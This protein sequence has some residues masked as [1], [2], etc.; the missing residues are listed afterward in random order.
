MEVNQQ[1]VQCPLLPGRTITPGACQQFRS[2]SEPANA[3]SLNFL[4]FFVQKV[5]FFGQVGTGDC[6]IAWSLAAPLLCYWQL[7]NRALMHHKSTKNR[8]IEVSSVLF[9]LYFTPCGYLQF[10]SQRWNMFSFNVVPGNTYF[11][12]IFWE[13]VW[14]FRAAVYL[15]F[16]RQVNQNCR[17]IKSPAVAR[18]TS[19]PDPS[20]QCVKNPICRSGF[21]TLDF[22]TLDFWGN[23]IRISDLSAG[24]PRSKIEARRGQ[25]FL[26]E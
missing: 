9:A 22:V 7:N 10:V 5:Q 11:S 18:L 23:Q 2:D 21:V 26:S 14:T 3:L 17:N 8:L 24:E 1:F 25:I 13:G 6:S 12:Q 20:F 4:L 15:L 16:F 19:I